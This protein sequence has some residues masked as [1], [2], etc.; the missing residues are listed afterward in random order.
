MFR[1]FSHIWTNVSF[2][3][4][5]HLNRVLKKW[6]YHSIH[7]PIPATAHVEIYSK[8]LPGSHSTWLT[9]PA[10]SLTTVSSFWHSTEACTFLEFW[11]MK[12]SGGGEGVSAL[13]GPPPPTAS[14]SPPLDTAMGGRGEGRRGERE[15]G[16]GKGQGRF[17][18]FLFIPHIHPPSLP[19]RNNGRR[20][21][22]NN[23]KR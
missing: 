11:N 14:R 9:T 6:N 16:R 13:G 5:Y 22:N 21:G 2:Y 10:C 23:R 18:H 7:S 12:W 3:N 4:C 1:K 17:K 19:L 15:I 8:Q 20:V